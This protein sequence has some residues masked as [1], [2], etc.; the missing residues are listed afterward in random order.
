VTV[1]D[2][3]AVIDLLLSTGVAVEVQAIIRDGAEVAAPDILVF[4]VLAVLRREVARG[5]LSYARASAAIADLGDLPLELFPTLALRDRAWSLRSNLT[6]ADALFV[7]LAEQLGEPLAT[8]DLPLARAALA[9]A[10][11]EIVTL[12]GAI[13]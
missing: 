4:E 7:A 9:H 11:A 5:G 2:S 8:K 13:A 3:S 12:G 1:I 6:A 10:R